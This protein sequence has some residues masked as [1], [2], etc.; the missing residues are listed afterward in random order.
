MKRFL[1]IFLVLILGTIPFCSS[2]ENSGDS[3]YD[4]IDEIWRSEMDVERQTWEAEQR[5]RDRQT[6]CVKSKCCIKRQPCIDKCN[7]KYDNGMRDDTYSD[8]VGCMN[9]CD[10]DVVSCG[11]SKCNTYVNGEFVSSICD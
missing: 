1:P 10:A 8:W 3:V 5:E 7:S 6:A 4:P 11:E 9:R 2:T